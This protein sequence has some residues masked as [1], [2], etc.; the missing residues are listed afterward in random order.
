[1]TAGTM[2]SWLLTQETRALLTRLDRIKSFAMSETM[3]PAAALTFEAQAGIDAFL[4]RER[5][6]L[7]S[8]AHGFLRWLAGSEGRLAAPAEM[9]RRFTYL[10]LRFNTVIAN[11]DLFSE[12]LSQ[13]SEVDNGVLLAGLDVVSKDALS[14]PGVFEAPP[15]ICY[16]ARGPGAAIRRAHTP[17]PGGGK[18]PVAIVRVPR[19]RMVGSAIASS[20][21]HEVGHQAAALLELVPSL[22]SIFHAVPSRGAEARAWALWEN[23][24]SEIVADL[25]SVGRVGITATL[26]LMGVLSLPRAFVFRANADGVHPMPWVRVVL[27]SA[28]GQSLYPHPQWRRIARLWEQLYPLGPLTGPRRDSHQ[29]AVRHPPCLRGRSGQPSTAGPQWAFAPGGLRG[30]SAPA[31]PPAGAPPRMESAAAPPPCRTSFFGLRRHRPGQSRR[32]HHAR[33]GEQLTRRVPQVLGVA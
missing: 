6:A 30:R 15:V 8:V 5:R 21:V 3:V 12:A 25:W 33:G 14:L 10:R 11:F 24:L 31:S 28:I 22:R 27:S 18:S 29:R 4:L 2:A 13:R 17:L 9:Q 23:W 20:L 16:L 26:G 1:M 7:R 32:R 19:E